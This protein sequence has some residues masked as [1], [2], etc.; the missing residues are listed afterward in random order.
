[1]WN[2]NQLNKHEEYYKCLD[3]LEKIGEFVIK[4]GLERIEAIMENLGNPEKKLK[5]IIVGGTN[6]KGTAC[7]KLEDLI[8]NNDLKVG[9]FTSPHLHTIR[10]RF[11]INGK[12]IEKNEFVE[13]FNR[14]NEVAEKNGIAVTYFE[15]TT[16]MA[17]LYFENNEVDLAV[18]EVGMGGEFDAVNIGRGDIIVLTTLGLDHM[19]YLGNTIEKIGTTKGKIVKENSEV[20]TG[21]R[22]ENWRYIPKCVKIQFGE[23]SDEWTECVSNLLGIKYEKRMIEIPG[24]MERRGN[25]ILDGAHNF[26]ALERL[27]KMVDKIE[28]VI[29]SCMKDK[30]VDRMLSTLPKNVELML[31]PM[32]NKRG[33]AVKEMIKAAERNRNIYGS[34]ESIE[35]AI[36]TI[37]KQKTL[38]TGSF[39]CVSEARKI[40]KMKGSEEN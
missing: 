6:G 1:M 38:I 39:Y 34:F 16:A 35:N 20:V 40:V 3:E 7:Y 10:E 23:D 36:K 30:D 9:C 25:F 31:C 26:Q 8:K 18:M 33:M 21:W 24:R 2:G 19:K 13:M 15:I 5:T 22:K 4:P 12:I 27:T 32:K 28:K 29:F 14:V 17:Y 11:R 37:E